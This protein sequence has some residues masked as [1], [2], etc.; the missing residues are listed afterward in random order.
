MKLIRI[1]P[2]DVAL[3]LE[4]RNFK[5]KNKMNIILMAHPVTNGGR[6]DDVTICDVTYGLRRWCVVGGPS[7]VKPL[8]LPV[9][10]ITY[11]FINQ[12]D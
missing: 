1:L 3:C 8:M 2:Y 7:C 11:T 6:L 4:K 5:R 10:L 9:N 12:I